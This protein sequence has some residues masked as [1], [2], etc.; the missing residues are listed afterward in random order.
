MTAFSRQ[1]T[2]PNPNIVTDALGTVGQGLT[3]ATDIGKAVALAAA[4][5]TLAT[6]GQEI[7]GFITSIEP[8]TI[9][10]GY[11]YGG[12]LVNGRQVAVV[13]ANQGGTAMAVGDLVVA[14]TQTA[15]GDAGAFQ[16]WAAPGTVPSTPT[17]PTAR[18]KT[19]TPTSCFWKC[20][21]LIEGSGVAGKKV[22]LERI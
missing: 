6:G 22:L 21:R 3:A 8:A 7:Y 4:S 13:G 16:S 5:C 17:G 1:V 12:V 2:V 11:A 18:V 19:G 9:N 10:D 15:A 20:I 14:D